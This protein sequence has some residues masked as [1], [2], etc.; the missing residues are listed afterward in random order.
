MKS[1]QK[2]YKNQRIVLRVYIQ[3]ELLKRG[4]V[5]ASSLIKKRALSSQCEPEHEN[6]LDHVTGQSWYDFW[7]SNLVTKRRVGMKAKILFFLDSS[8]YS[9]KVFHPF[10]KQNASFYRSYLK[11][12]PE[13]VTKATLHWMIFHYVMAHVHNRPVS[14]R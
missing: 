10:S 11:Q 13:A 3:A 1:L 7:K 8:I 2:T 5:S 6:P 4:A 12:D 9:C 14:I